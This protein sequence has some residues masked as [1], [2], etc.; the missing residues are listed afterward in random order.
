MGT[1]SID[2]KQSA[3]SM[4]LS[5]CLSMFFYYQLTNFPTKLVLNPT[6]PAYTYNRMDMPINR[7][8]NK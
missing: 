4:S 8:V 3:V 1:D 7:G 5:P 6:P 2:T